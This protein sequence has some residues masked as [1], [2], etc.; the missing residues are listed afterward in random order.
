MAIDRGYVAN[1][2]F[3]DE[4]GR[5]TPNVEWSESHRPHFEAQ[6][7]PWLPVVRYEKELEAWFVISSGKIVAVDREENL[8]PA[9]YRAKFAV[10]VSTA[11]T[12]TADDYNAGTIDL[13]TGA[14]YATNGTTTYTAAQV[15]TALRSRGLIR[16]TEYAVDFVSKA[17]GTAS[18]NYYQAAG[19]DV[20]NPATYTYHNFKAQELI[21]VTCDYVIVAPVLPAVATTETM[22]NAIVNTASGLLDFFDGTSARATGWFGSTAIHGVPRYASDVAAGADIVGYMFLY[23]PVAHITAESPITPSVAGMTRQVSSIKTIAAA[24]DYFIDYEVGMMFLYEAD[25]NAIPSPWAVTSTITYYHYESGVAAGA[26]RTSSYF[27]A[28]G[29]LNVGDFVTY[30]ADSN[31]IKAVL[32]IGTAEGYDAGGNAY[33]VDPDY[34]AGTDAA[35]SLQIE[36]AVMGYQNGV[37]GQVIGEITFPRGNLDRVRTAFPTG[38]SPNIYTGMTNAIMKTPG[39]ATGGRTDQL[40]YTNSAEKL[41]IVNLIHR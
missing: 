23:S 39:S 18:Y 29:D 5:I 7:A 3:Y 38:T 16:S 20:R 25:G 40:T 35:I 2:K 9:G 6:V 24:G 11:L 26:A 17:I 33:T 4:M 1:H 34:S 37:I 27:C 22:A 15:T 21:A 19:T 13:T 41:L 32:D 8:V 12:Y 36:K 30:N 31:L 28:T 14:A 10:G